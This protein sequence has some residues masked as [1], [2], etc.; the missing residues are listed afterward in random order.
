M[1]AQA[2]GNVAA[3]PASR[4]KPRAGLVL[5]GGGARAAYQVGVAGLPRAIPSILSAVH[6]PARSMRRP[7]PAVPMISRKA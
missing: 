5:T 6:P 4:Q 3:F 7:L 2:A 1:S